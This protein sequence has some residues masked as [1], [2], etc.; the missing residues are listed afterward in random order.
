MPAIRTGQWLEYIIN[1][2]GM[3]KEELAKKTE[4]SITDI[5]NII[6][7]S[8]F[9]S[10]W[11][12]ER[13]INEVGEKYKLSKDSEDIICELKEEIALYGVSYKCN[14][15]YYTKN[16]HVI[17][18]DYLLLEDMKEGYDEELSKMKMKI[19]TLGEALEFFQGQNKIL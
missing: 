5:S 7:G 17:F 10:P 12:W 4:I 9:G 6:S 19:V 15:F 8:H 18:E 11:M 14:I 2:K 13:I 16:D 1:K 3:T